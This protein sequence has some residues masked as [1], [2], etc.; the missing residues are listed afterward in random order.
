MREIKFEF[1]VDEKVTTPFGEEGIVDTLAFDGNENTY[2]VKTKTGG[3][4][5]KEKHL[6]K[7]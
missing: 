2:F 6:T 3:E 5:L 1:D 4:W 7:L